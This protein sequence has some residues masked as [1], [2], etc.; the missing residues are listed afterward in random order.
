M[1]L[2]QRLDWED[3]VEETAVE[4][5]KPVGNLHMFAG[6]HGPAQDYPIYQGPNVIGRHSSCDITLPAQSVSKKHAVLCVT[7]DCHTICDNGSLNKTRRSKMALEPDVRYSLSTGD[8]LLFA[9]VAC[10]YTILKKIEAETTIAEDSE[11]DSML[12]PGTQAPL[13]IEKTPGAAIRRMGCGAVLARDSGDEDEEV[14]RGWSDG[15]EG[16]SKDALRTSRPA[17]GA[18]FSP[19]ADADTVVPESDEEN[20]TSSSGTRFT[21]LHL[22]CDSDID[23]RGT[24]TKESSFITSSLDKFTPAAVKEPA[25]EESSRLLQTNK[26]EKPVGEQTDEE[27]ELS[28]VGRDVVSDGELLEERKETSKDGAGDRSPCLG[29]TVVQKDTLDCG[30][31]DGGTKAINR[32]NSH[33]DKNLKNNAASIENLEVSSTSSHR[34]KDNDDETSRRDIAATTAIE[35]TQEEDNLKSTEEKLKVAADLC[36]DSDTDSDEDVPTTSGTDVKKKDDPEIKSDKAPEQ[37]SVDGTSDAGVHMDRDTSVDEDKEKISAVEHGGVGEI[38]IDSD[39]D[40]EDDKEMSETGDGNSGEVHKVHSVSGTNV[41]TGFDIDSDTD[42]E[43]ADITRSDGKVEEKKEK[44]HLDSDTDEEDNGDVSSTKV[45]KGD[46]DS[47]AV[48]LLKETKDEIHMDSDTDV[49]EDVNVSS[50]DVTKGKQ[51]LNIAAQEGFHVDSDT[52]VEDVD[53]SSTV[54]T[55]EKQDFSKSVKTAR[56]GL[57]LDSDTDVDEE[58]QGP[59]PSSAAVQSRTT[60]SHIDELQ[61]EMVKNEKKAVSVINKDAA[62]L[63]FDSDTDDDDGTSTE[64]KQAGGSVK[65][66]AEKNKTEVANEADALHI[67]SDTDEDDGTST[68][69]KKAGG[70]VK[71]DAE[72]NEAE[73]ANEADA[74]HMD[75]DTDLDEDDASMIINKPQ[76]AETAEGELHS[77]GVSEGGDKNLV[78]VAGSSVGVMGEVPKADTS[79]GS[80]KSNEV[81]APKADSQGADYELMAT[82]CF[83]EEPQ[84]PEEDL[85]DEEEATQAYILSSTWAEPHTFKRPSDPVGVLQISAVTLDK[86]EEEVDEN[87]IAETQLFCFG[88]DQSPGSDFKETPQLEEQ[89]MDNQQDTQPT[90]S[91]EG[92]R[93]KDQEPPHG[94]MIQEDTE[95]VSQ[96]LSANPPADTGT[97]LHLKRDV[98]AAVWMKGLQQQLETSDVKEDSTPEDLTEDEQD[99]PPLE[100]EATQSFILEVPNIQEHRKE[101]HDPS[102][103]A[104]HVD[105]KLAESA[106]PATENPPKDP[107]ALGPGVD[108]SATEILPTGLSIPER[109]ASPVPSTESTP[110]GPS[111]LELANESPLT[112]SSNLETGISAASLTEGPPTELSNLELDVSAVPATEIPPTELSNLELDVSA[113][114]ATE[115]PPNEL[116]NVEKEVNEDDATQAYSLNLP[117]SDANVPQ[118][119]L[120]VHSTEDATQPCSSDVASIASKEAQST[121]VSMLAVGEKET[122][123]TDTGKGKPSSKRG[124]SRSRKK[125]QPERSTE[126][127]NEKAQLSEQAAPAAHSAPEE[128]AELRAGELG[129]SG[130]RNVAS[131]TRR[132]TSTEDSGKLTENTEVEEE[133]SEGTKKIADEETSRKGRTSRASAKEE[134]PQVSTPVANRKRGQALKADVNLKRKK[135]DET[136]EAEEVRP[137][138][139]RGRPRK[140]STTDD[141]QTSAGGSRISN[142]KA[143][144]SEQA[145]PAAHSAPE[146]TAELHAGELGQSGPRIVASETTEEIEPEKDGRRRGRRKATED[147]ETKAKTKNELVVP[148][149]SRKR[150][151]RI[152][153]EAEPSTSGNNEISRKQP[154]RKSIVKMQEEEKQDESKKDFGSASEKCKKSDVFETLSDNHPEKIGLRSEFENVTG[155]TSMELIVGQMES[156]QERDV[157]STL[158]ESNRDK[159]VSTSSNNTEKNESTIVDLPEQLETISAPQNKKPVRGKRQ[160]ATKAKQDNTQ[161]TISNDK[162]ESETSGTNLET[163]DDFKIPTPRTNDLQ[164][165]GNKGPRGRRTR[166]SHISTSELLEHEKPKGAD[167]KASQNEEANKTSPGDQNSADTRSTRQRRNVKEEAKEDLQKEE[168]IGRSKRTINLGGNQKNKETNSERT[169]E[170]NLGRSSLPKRT[171]KNSKEETPKPE[172]DVP[173]VEKIEEDNMAKLPRRTRKGYKEEQKLEE[174]KGSLESSNTA[175]AQTTKRTQRSSKGQDIVDE[176]T[177]K[178]TVTRKGRNSKSEDAQLGEDQGKRSVRTRRLS[179]EE[180]VEETTTDTTKENAAGQNTSRRTRRNVKADEKTESEH[181]GDIIPDKELSQSERSSS[182]TRRKTSTEDSGKL[183]ENTEVEE[184]QSEGTKKIADE[185]TPRKGRTSRASAKEEPPQVSTPVANRKRGQALK[186]DVNLKRKKSDE[187][188]EAEEERPAGRR[189]RP[190]KLSTTDDSQTSAGGSR[191]MSTPEPSPSR[192]SRLRQS[193]ALSNL[194]EVLTPRRT[195]RLS[196]STLT[197]SPYIP[198]SGAP[199]KVL[200]TGVV[201]AMG[202]EIIRSLGGD[203]ADSVFDCTH[204]ITDR[205]R[206]TVK[207]LCALARGIPIVTLDWIDKCKKSG[208]FLSHTKY[209]VKDKEQEKNFN[210]VLSQSLQKAKRSPLFEGYDIHITP[211]VKPDPESM[212]DI[213]CCSGANF[214]PKMPRTFKEKC[215]IVSCP[216]DAAR[217]KSVPS[218]IPVTTAEFILSGILR[219]EVNPSAY[220]LSSE[221]EEDNAPAPAKRRR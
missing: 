178:E 169:L 37:S 94:E 34:L 175:E 145:A 220:L 129:Q 2:T 103:L 14:R 122:E 102:S 32:S 221:M 217:C 50:T 116:S 38:N 202:E 146:E 140:L 196:V 198:Q 213:V 205:V 62:D 13:V 100:L 125:E 147:S 87:A 39:T 192:S 45:R 56:D 20:D 24:P 105:T 141:S 86:S 93:Q 212:K 16:G 46:L 33:E 156:D 25:K 111:T 162:T 119:N 113:V 71:T 36:L 211:S 117:V 172:P 124:L 135:S 185:E 77:D 89:V 166:T 208:C 209:L 132:K 109:D 21:S 200:F 118:S 149:A 194:P 171:R 47:V 152:A 43:D 73:A 67:D 114:P 60:E 110:T 84:E 187:I 164:D 79:T 207:F 179:K 101:H 30:L 216:E 6:T 163:Q 128:T 92:S 85:P 1:D 195:G 176:E 65:T 29:G 165:G 40:V 78:E 193:P 27:K 201:D 19:D 108:V 159:K 115:S 53:V 153:L 139:R 157:T 23:N 59:G 18:F 63:H 82:Q 95:P 184:E 154:N 191:E 104:V 183:T 143:Q 72:Q 80:V 49:E 190:R 42:V 189:G 218:K 68:G 57:P 180:V 161:E 127:S 199:P 96:C 106:E 107:I 48:V 11:D 121:G 197:A 170:D 10:R 136:S 181:A 81:E 54:V 52:D 182:R 131:E 7:G 28:S 151:S 168:Q 17:A 61:F 35:S 160:A 5:H 133:Q 173:E 130:P 76:T 90:S 12:V 148:T 74:L 123:L 91:V 44:F 137:A 134:P 9:D 120:E 186:A 4:R 215:V 177:V 126:I 66:D 174:N 3:E 158:L 98:P 55:K 112:E 83:L 142:E 31:K 75:S 150:S 58:D 203:I 26:D 219:Q 64:P 22:H 99:L 69:P 41:S 214:L 188:S 70:S 210:F 144:L 97:L 8:F 155:P 51:T 15:G 167:T 206:R 88:V 138:G 204:L